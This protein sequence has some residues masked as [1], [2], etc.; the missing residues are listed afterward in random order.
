M[1]KIQI[2]GNVGSEPTVN[3]VNDKNV[4]NFNVAVNNGRGDQQSTNWY[5]C[6][7][8]GDSTRLNKLK[9]SIVKGHKLFVDGQFDI[10]TYNDKSQLT[11]RVTS[12]EFLTPKS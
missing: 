10:E 12:I 8:W 4:L 7:M 6:A 5:R 1:Q 2:I 3:Q 11:I 9:A